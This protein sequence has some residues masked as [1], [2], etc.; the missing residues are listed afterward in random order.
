MGGPTRLSPPPLP[1]DYP[2]RHEGDAHDG[3]GDDERQV[4]SLVRE[5]LGRDSEGHG[6]KEQREPQKPHPG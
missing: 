3:V 1:G 4:T 2:T 5:P 6:A